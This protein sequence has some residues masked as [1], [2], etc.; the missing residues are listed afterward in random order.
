MLHRISRQRLLC[1]GS[2]RPIRCF[3][4]V[5]DTSAAT[6][7]FSA[8]AAPVSPVLLYQCFPLPIFDIPI[9][10]TAPHFPAIDT[11]KVAPVSP[12]LLCQ[13]FPCR[14]SMSLHRFG[15]SFHLFLKIAAP[16]FKVAVKGIA[17]SRRRKG[18]RPPR[19]CY[20]KR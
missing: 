7:H 14:F 20:R 13:C 16:F 4:P 10:P 12:V 19:L 6:P 17:G 5:F 15:I 18:T 11:A 8:K 9:Q 2:F 1:S 3:L